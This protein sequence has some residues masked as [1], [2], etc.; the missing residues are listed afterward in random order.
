L[1]PDFVLVPDS[2][3]TEEEGVG[4]FLLDLWRQAIDSLAEHGD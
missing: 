4:M 1:C 3:E 2:Y